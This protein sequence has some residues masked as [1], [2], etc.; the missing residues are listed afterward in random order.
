MIIKGKNIRIG[1]WARPYVEELLRGNY[2]HNPLCYLEGRARQSGKSHKEGG[3][4]GFYYKSWQNALVKLEEVG[5]PVVTIDD[6]RPGRL[7][8]LFVLQKYFKKVLKSH[9]VESVDSYKLYTIEDRSLLI[10]DD[11]N[12]SVEMVEIHPPW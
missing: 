11:Q 12:S 8:Y 9:L 7:N 1:R 5:Y 6:F 3:W 4:L 2:I 10:K